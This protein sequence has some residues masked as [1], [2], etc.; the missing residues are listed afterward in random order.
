EVLVFKNFINHSSS[1]DFKGET[2]KIDEQSMTGYVA[3]H[4]ESILINNLDEDGESFPFKINKSYDKRLR[5]KTQNVLTV[6]MKN[7]TNEVLGV[8][9]IL[10]KK[11]NFDFELLVES[12]FINHVIPFDED[13]IEMILSLASQTAV[14]VERLSL[15]QK[16]SR[17]VSLTRTT[18]INFFN[19]M[20]TA[21]SQIGEDILDEQ[22]KFKKYATL[23]PLT[24]L[25]TK[26]EGVS[27]FKQQLEFA[28]F[29]GVK[30][31]VSFID[32]NDLKVV[33]DNF[34]HLAGDNLLKNIGQIIQD[35][36]RQNDIIF[37]YGGDEFILIFYNADLK[38]AERI[39]IRI[40]SKLEEFNNQSGLPYQLSVS[41]GLSEYDYR[42]NQSID[43]L[44]S[45]ADKKMYEYKRIYKQ[46]KNSL[47]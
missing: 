40:L 7:N 36:A 3:L 29:N 38:A 22:E 12:D 43:E 5:Y 28:R 45:E 46:K 24:G 35:T 30:V 37:R 13:D 17:N 39:W 21:M 16:L 41:Y 44:I 18:L 26:Q 14:L 47:M 25:M 6:P 9:Q 32:A 34:G 1:T 23:D 31:V 4:G 42:I 33:N 10:N 2:L 20:K 11:D 27:F 8:L 15:N 19:S